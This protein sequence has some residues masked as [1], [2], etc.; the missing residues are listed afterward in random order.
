[1]SLYLN[2]LGLLCAAGNSKS[3]ILARLF[4]GD[5]LGLIESDK[6]GYKTIVGQC[7]YELPEID[8]QDILFTTAG[9]TSFYWRRLAKSGP[10]SITFTL[11]NMAQ[12]GLAWC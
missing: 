11:R 5:R 7:N 6:F 9:I 12:T 3:E 10:Q 4:A 1:M 8:Q 2:D